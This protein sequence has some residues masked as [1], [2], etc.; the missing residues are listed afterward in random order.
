MSAKRPRLSKKGGG[1]QARKTKRQLG[2]LVEEVFISNDSDYEAVVGHVR[3]ATNGEVCIENAHPQFN[4][5]FYVVHNGIVENAPTN[6]L[7][8]RWL[9]GLLAYYKG[10]LK[11]VYDKIE[12]DNAFIFINKLT[13]ISKSGSVLT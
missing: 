4:E 1:G 2:P 9:I 12:G 13:Y 8:T 5:H 6:I 10:D 3:W 11:T 7:D